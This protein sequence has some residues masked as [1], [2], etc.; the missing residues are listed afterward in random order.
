MGDR[1][2]RGE[3]RRGG[4][5]WPVGMNVNTLPPPPLP[6]LCTQAS[7]KPIFLRRNKQKKELTPYGQEDNDMG[8]EGAEVKS[9][10]SSWADLRGKAKVSTMR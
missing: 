8:D 9:L 1:D 10:E 2:E 3:G 5:G 4:A 6:S 7:V